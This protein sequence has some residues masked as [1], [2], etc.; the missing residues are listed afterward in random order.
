MSFFKKLFGSKKTGDGTDDFYGT[1]RICETHKVLAIHAGMALIIIES[2][3]DCKRCKYK[4]VTEAK[5]LKVL[6]WT[7]ERLLTEIYQIFLGRNPN[8]LTQTELKIIAL[9]KKR[10]RFETKKQELEYF[11]K[12]Y[13]KNPQE[14]ASV[15]FEHAMAAVPEI[16]P[17]KVKAYFN[18]VKGT[19]GSKALVEGS[20]EKVQAA[21]LK[22]LQR[23]AAE[24]GFEGFS[25]D[26]IANDECAQISVNYRR[27]FV[28]V[29]IWKTNKGF[30]ACGDPNFK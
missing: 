14:A 18:S 22:N 20:R 23:L 19:F 27:T 9:C 17:Q 29:R 12:M 2:N 10:L 11:E 5:A 26:T 21:V 24:S 7:E 16:S 28:P 4:P 3:P 1:L 30:S 13:T 6:G 15:V 25:V 8:S